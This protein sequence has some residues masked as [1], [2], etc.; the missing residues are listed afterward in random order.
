VGR[1]YGPALASL[2]LQSA[3][4]ILREDAL[5]AVPGD[6]T[7]GALLLRLFFRGVRTVA[8]PCEEIAAAILSGGV[9]A[10]VLIHE[11]LLNLERK[12]LR[13]LACLGALWQEKTGLPIPVGL[14][15]V[16]RSLGPDMMEA[17]AAAVRGSME[18]AGRER[19]EASKWAMG[20]THQ[21]A[22]GIAEKYLAMFANEDTLDLADDCLQALGTLYAMAFEAGLIESVP[23]VEP[24]GRRSAGS[25]KESAA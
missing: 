6:S 16:R 11:E 2:R 14:N 7:T 21:A 8:L 24:V 12:G 22:D 3:E 1:G 10:G 4:D 18:M 20:Y 15:V 23:A 9:D 17:A 19:S 25:S 13:R 5:V